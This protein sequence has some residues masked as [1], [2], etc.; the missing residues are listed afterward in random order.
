[1]SENT[2]RLEIT[3]WSI[4]L[5]WNNG[6]KEDIGNIDDETASKVQE[7]LD[8]YQNQVNEELKGKQ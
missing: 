2:E 8:D 1:M 7:Y 3:S 6:K 4:I 5:T